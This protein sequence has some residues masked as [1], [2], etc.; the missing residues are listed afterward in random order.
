MNS[1]IEYIRQLNQSSVHLQA[2]WLE[3]LSHIDVGTDAQ[4]A[5]PEI[6]LTQRTEITELPYRDPQPP[7][8]QVSHQ[9]AASDMPGTPAE[10]P[11]VAP[12]QDAATPIMPESN[13]GDVHVISTLGQMPQEFCASI[14][15]TAF[16]TTDGPVLPN[17]ITPGSA[18]IEMPILDAGINPI[19]P[20]DNPKV[21]GTA[22]AGV[23]SPIQDHLPVIKP[24]AGLESP[25]ILND[26]VRP[27]IMPLRQRR[28]TDVI[29][30]VSIVE[31]RMAPEMPLPV[32]ADHA[33]Q[34]EAVQED[35]LESNP[36]AGVA[37]Q[38]VEM[39]SDFGMKGDE[40]YNTDT[41]T[42]DEVSN[43][44]ASPAS[45]DEETATTEST[46]PTG[47]AS[48][49]CC[50]P[51]DIRAER[52]HYEKTKRQRLVDSIVDQV[53]ERF[54]GNT[55]PVI[56]LIGAT[57]EI[58]V[59]S[60]A[61]RIATCMATRDIGDILL[62]DGNLESRQLTSVLSLN[63]RPGITDA[64]QKNVPVCDVITQTDHP[65]LKVVG[66]GTLADSSITDLSAATATSG[67]FKDDFGYTIVSGGIAGDTLT[68]TWSSVVDGI[69]LI[70]DMDQSDRNKTVETVDYFRHLGARIVGCI[71]TRA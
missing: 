7:V 48:R 19:P 42:Q 68:D 55:R 51:D 35:A 46:G 58:D 10:E 64:F 23:V 25:A 2:D 53:V 66:T 54:P 6:V 15:D 63:G 61:S 33:S 8:T 71:A 11:E 27:T 13:P 40:I 69:Y 67:S 4:V 70:V 18:S 56:M 1:T 50:F 49:I 38:L 3:R 44:V 20:L 16:A 29:D 9:P 47:D 34:A 43:L 5:T 14:S 28:G 22:S 39:L 21:E 32:Q 17:I 36:S 26:I 57:R 52:F 45:G 60:A 41:L 65:R 37:P 12:I 31:N 59:D 30:P 24:E 62:V